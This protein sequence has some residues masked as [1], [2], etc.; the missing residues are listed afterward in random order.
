MMYEMFT[1]ELKLKIYHLYNN[2][3]SNRMS[4]I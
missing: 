2:T 1:Y 4:H 3:V